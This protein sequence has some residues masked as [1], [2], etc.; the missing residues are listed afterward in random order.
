MNE[1]QKKTLN[2]FS[3]DLNLNNYV[4][5]C[6]KETPSNFSCFVEG[7]FK[8]GEYYCWYSQD[9]YIYNKEN[10]R[11]RDFYKTLGSNNIE[12]A[13]TIRTN[14]SVEG[15]FENWFDGNKNAF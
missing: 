4:L 9:V 5:R 1:I 10:E 2:S 6:I 3:N 8:K 13:L 7:K 15:F 14:L 11:V 12:N